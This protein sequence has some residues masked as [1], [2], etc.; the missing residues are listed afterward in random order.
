[1]RTA[2]DISGRKIG[3]TDAR[4]FATGPCALTRGAR[5]ASLLGWQSATPEVLMTRRNWMSETTSLHD[6]PL[7]RICFPTTHD[8]ATSALQDRLT[9]EPIG[10]NGKAVLDKLK[11]VQDAIASVPGIGSILPNPAGFVLHAITDPSKRLATATSRSIAE[12]LDAGI[13]GF[14]LR[15]YYDD[16]TRQLTTFHGLVGTPM[17]TVL[18]EMK[19]FLAANPGEILFITMGHF[20]SVSDRGKQDF[21]KLVTDSL[22]SYAY[23]PVWTSDT[24]IRN[25]FYTETW[26][27][28]CQV[29]KKTVSRV[30]LV[31][32]DG[33][34][35][36]SDTPAPFWPIT[37]SPPDNNADNRVLAGFYT[38]TSNLDKALST[39]AMQLRAAV[40]ADLPFALY[41]TLTPGDDDQIPII[42]GSLKKPIAELAGVYPLF[43]PLL[44]PISAGLAI[45]SATRD[46]NTLAE[47]A[48]KV[49][50]RLPYY[51]TS[52]ILEGY[53]GKN[54][55][56]YLY[57]DYYETTDVVD[58]AIALSQG[59]VPQWSGNKK[60][61]IGRKTP[62]T[63]TSPGAAW[64]GNTLYMAYRGETSTDMLFASFDGKKWSGN[65]YIKVKG[66]TIATRTSPALAVF[67]DKLHMT[68]RGETSTDLRLAT[69]DGRQWSG[70]D[71][72]KVG[73]DTIS[74][75]TSPALA[76]FRGKLHMV[77]RGE[78]STEIRLAVFDG[79]RWTGNKKIQVGDDVPATRTSPALA[80]FG[81]RLYM[82]YRGFISTNILVSVFDGS[83]WTGNTV[84]VTGNGTPA[85]SESPALAVQR[86]RLLMFYRGETFADV[87]QCAFD[88][89]T[90]TGN[91]KL[92][93]ISGIHP[94]TA[95]E[96]ALAVRDGVL[97]MVYRGDSQ[98]DIFMATRSFRVLS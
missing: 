37:Y 65:D 83:K 66:E 32:G 52:N 59:L 91:E 33:K 1:M 35:K 50:Q 17:T 53:S 46:F 68:Y 84:V 86:D 43:A 38:N 14:D 23:A 20:L 42:V 18:A 21:A 88:G 70:N 8:S 9:P 5:R 34:G 28:L 72:I 45:Y 24:R 57:L 7:R 10:E 12:Q 92:K 54:P 89:S 41:M 4:D 15:I 25:S 64:Q 47:L 31:W 56:S 67:R 80:V 39:Q 22:G 61:L 62:K 2:P 29:N 76:V 19:A 63:A 78:T 58:L 74:T 85:T 71:K 3:W 97:T 30:L 73:N 48:A 36:R 16:Q 55:I 95:T 75:A 93:D 11:E 69:F 81:N 44:L 51:V 77:Y 49:D 79:N 82:A 27:T 40:K 94:G 98:T 60:I 87:Y 90:W 6:T 96:P 13:R 26:N